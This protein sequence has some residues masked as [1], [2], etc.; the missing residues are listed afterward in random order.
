MKTK[1]QIL[2]ESTFYVFTMSFIG[3][4]F[5]SVLNKIFP[6]NFD[7]IIGVSCLS[8]FLITSALMGYLFEK[9]KPLWLGFLQYA[10]IGFFSAIIT[11]ILVVIGF[12]LIFE[13][14]FQNASDF[15]KNAFGE[16]SGISGIIL[17]IPMII[18]TFV[19]VVFGMLAYLFLA[20]FLGNW[21][22]S[23]LLQI[24]YNKYLEKNPNEA[25]SKSS[26]LK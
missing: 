15:W 11:I 6:E 22:F 4:V 16:S 7:L 26:D 23:F 5:Y 20:F 10:A 14:L 9:E 8:S 21:L 19:F 2:K 24:V 12:P 17:I 1:L 3:F 18:L 13:L 25:N